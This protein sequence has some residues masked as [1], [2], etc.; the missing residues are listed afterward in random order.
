MIFFCLCECVRVCFVVV[1]VC[2]SMALCKGTLIKIQ[3]KVSS[4]KKQQHLEVV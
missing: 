2:D 4:T 1:A 3:F